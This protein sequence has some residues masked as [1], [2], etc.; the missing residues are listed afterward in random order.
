MRLKDFLQE[1]ILLMDGA[2]GTYYQQ[3][4]EHKEEI[5]E[6][7]NVS[8]PEV[9]LKIHREYLEAGADIIRTNTFAVNSVVLPGYTQESREQMLRLACRVA[10]QAVEEEKKR[11]GRECFVAADIGPVTGGGERSEE[12]ILAEYYRMCDVFLSEGMDIFWLET[13]SSIELIPEILKYIK[14]K[15]ADAFCS[16]SFCINKNGFYCA[17]S[18]N[19]TVIFSADIFPDIYNSYKFSFTIKPLLYRASTPSFEKLFCICNISATSKKLFSSHF[20]VFLTNN[21][22]IKLDDKSEYF[23]LPAPSATAQTR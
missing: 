14:E 1:N 23:A 19:K 10:K 21:L 7:A 20:F 18:F 17:S 4:Q 11:T 12:E 6:L 3:L 9:V 22:Q 16:V 13:F 5:A 15:A 8:E 2:M